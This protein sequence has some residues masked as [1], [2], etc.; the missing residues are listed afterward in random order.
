MLAAALSD[1][2]QLF[3]NDHTVAAYEIQSSG[4]VETLLSSLNPM[5]SGVTKQIFSDRTNT[6]KKSFTQ[7]PTR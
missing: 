1:L 3:A 7:F 4:I 2:A 5:E 6:F